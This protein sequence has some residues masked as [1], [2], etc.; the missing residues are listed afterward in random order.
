MQDCES[1]VAAFH[2]REICFSL[3]RKLINSDWTHVILYI[4]ID[5]PIQVK[6]DPLPPKQALYFASRLAF[7]VCCPC[8]AKIS[9]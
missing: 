2:R 6:M 9:I 7:Q 3:P 5:S 4:G 1:V 8:D